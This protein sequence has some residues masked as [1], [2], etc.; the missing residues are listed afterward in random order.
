NELVTAV[1]AVSKFDQDALLLATK[2]GEIKRTPLSEFA[3]VRRNGL[4]AMNLEAGDELISAK[5]ART[6]DHVV[7]L[8][9]HGVANRFA[10]KD[11]RAASRTSGGV[12]GL[13]LVAGDEIVGMEIVIR[14]GQL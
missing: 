14:G 10:V 1:V 4:I 11:L 6:D 7:L 9:A 3:S 8:S 13:R 2:K 5:L 12:R